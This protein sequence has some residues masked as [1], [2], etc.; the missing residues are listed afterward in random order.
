MCEHNGCEELCSVCEAPVRL[1]VLDTDGSPIDAAGSVLTPAPIAPT[2]G[3]LSGLLSG[4]YWGS[5]E[6][7]FG[8]TT[9]LL[10]Y[11]SL[12]APNSELL[13]FSE[14][15]DGGKEIFRDALSHWD[16][17]SGLNLTESGSPGSAE[18]RIAA[19]TAPL[20]AWAY[21]PSLDW[22]GGGD[23]W[24]DPE[25]I[26]PYADDVRG[27]TG[28]VGTYAH[29]TAM[30]EVGHAL[31]MEH[32]HEGTSL[33]AAYDSIEYSVMSYKSYVGHDG[34]G[35]TNETHGFAQSLMMLDIAA[36]Q[37]IYGADYTTRSGDTTYSF[38]PATGEMLVDGVSHA[39]PAENRVFRTLWD[40]GGYDTL[41]FATY[42]SSIS[43]NLNPGEATDLDTGGIGQKSRLGYEAGNW[44]YASANI[45]MS[46]LFQNDT[47][48]LIESVICGGGDDVLIGNSADNLLCGGLGLDTYTLGSGNDTIRGS[49]AEVIGDIVTDFSAGDQVVVTDIGANQS[50]EVGADGV[51]RLV[52]GSSGDDTGGGTDPDVGGDPG[53][54]EGSG[55]TDNDPGYD[56]TDDGGL[57]VR[58]TGK[59]DRYESHSEDGQTVLGMEGTDKIRTG[60]GDDR[61][62]ADGGNDNVFAGAGNDTVEGGA[63]NDRLNGELGDDVMF[64]G[65]GRDN[66]RGG[67]GHD[68]QYGEAGDDLLSGNDGN[69]SLSGGDGKD[70][71]DGGRGTN[72][73]YGGDGNDRLVGREGDDL[74]YGGNGSDE[75]AGGKGNDTF[76]FHVDDV[77]T[78]TIRFDSGS[79]I[80]EINGFSGGLDDLNFSDGRKGVTI[81]FG[82]SGSILVLSK[83]EEDFQESDFSFHAGTNTARELSPVPLSEVGVSNATMTNLTD[84]DDA[85]SL[86]SIKTGMKFNLRG[87]DDK[88][89][90]SRGNDTIN[91]GAGDDT[92]KAGSG[93]DVILGGSGEDEL[94]GQGGNDVFVF[95]AR[96]ISTG[97]T[98]FDKILDFRWRDD[99]IRLEGFDDSSVGDLEFTI[100]NRKL[101]IVVDDK[102]TIWLKTLRDESV[103]VANDL[104]DFV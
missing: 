87:G 8:F 103:F 19:S 99:T 101:Q 35:Y 50:T 90:A 16:E 94:F 5:N 86:T 100:H 47:R 48:S 64:G 79:D 49:I 46:L 29:L 67:E 76:V 28:A 7:S 98:E 93:D 77:G 61:I 20:T 92:I 60:A 78:D 33:G 38:N 70:R 11:V 102:Q 95:R 82:G 2:T 88:L 17:V 81:D 6:I 15:G 73:L 71:L 65:G 104:I 56:F 4:S 3:D 59:R 66:M 23:I 72:V 26:T 24:V 40:G 58:L 69:D 74:L 22:A 54:E 85:L 27:A 44:V 42:T 62:V 43:V 55:D 83:K 32:P 25:E 39:V 52:E 30:H 96:D 10:D 75:L 41:D 51:I 91:G 21:V 57:T 9:S 84:G 34:G 37:S 89:S 1:A 97:S 31:G 12:D 68:L 36:I 53:D 63:G 45:Y 13:T 80:I 14:L 18:I